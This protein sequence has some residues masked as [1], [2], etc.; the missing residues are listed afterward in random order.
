MTLCA[1]CGEPIHIDDLGGVMGVSNK[2]LWF[3]NNMVCIIQVQ[4]MVKE[5]EDNLMKPEVISIEVT[6]LQVDK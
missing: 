3:H 6:S 4:E 2:K 5:I 1:G